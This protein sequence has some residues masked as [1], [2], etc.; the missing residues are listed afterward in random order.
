MNI[1]KQRLFII[2]VFIHS[3]SYLV[4]AQCAGSDVTIEVCNKDADVANRDFD[5]FSQL[6]GSPTAGGTWS[7][8]N[9]EN[10]Y[11][12]NQT[13][14]I[15]D[16]WRINNFGTHSFRYFN[17]DCNQTATVTINLGGYP[18]EDNI[19]GSANA[20]GDDTNVNLH[21]F[22][23]SNVDGKVQD[24][25]GLWEEDPSTVT[26]QL[27]DNI[28]DARAA[29]TGIYIFTYTVPTVNGC[30]SRTATVVLEV[31]PPP[32]AGIA[33]SLTFCA[34]DDFSTYTNFDLNE[35]LA[36]EDPN[37]TW[38]EVG[39]NQLSDLNDSFINIQ[40]LY[41]NF[42]YNTYSFTYTVYPTHPVCE[43]TEVTVNIDIL[44][45]LD[46]DIV[47]D[48]ICFG[49]DYIV[50]LTYDDSILHNGSFLIQYTVNGVS[51]VASASLLDG[52]GSFIVDPDL[53]PLN[54]TVT[55]SVIGIDGVTPMRDVCPTV[56]VPPTTFLVASSKAD[57]QDICLQND[58]TVTISEILDASGNLANGPFTTE[59]ILTA[60]DASTTTSDS[61]ELEFTNGN[62]TF[63]IPGSNFA[64]EGEYEVRPTIANTFTTNCP[65]ADS[66]TVTPLP[67][68]IKL[69]L[70]VDNNC[71]ATQID[72]LVDAP[73]LPNGAYTITYDVTELDTNT[74]LTTNTINFTGGTA[75]YQ[76]DVDA[77]PV[78]NYT[79]SVRSSQNDITPCRIDFEF[80]ENEIFSRGGVP[81]APQ[82]STN[83]IFCLSDFPGGPT[84]MDIEVTAA[85][86]ILFYDTLTDTTILPISTALVDGEDYFI[87][88]TDP[89]NNCEGTERIQVTVNFSN[90][91][92][93]TSTNSNPLFC[94]LDN[95][96]LSD[97]IIDVIP[98]S[99]ITWFN[100]GNSELEASTV[101]VDGQS[102]FAATN[103]GGC[104][105]SER[106][107]VIPTVITVTPTSLSVNNL[108][109]CGLDNPT[110]IELRSLEDETENEVFW[111]ST[112]TSGTALTDDVPL[113]IDTVYYAENYNTLTGCSSNT[114]V[115]VTIDFSDCDPE[116]YD[117][118]IPD[119]FSP[120]ADGRNDTFFIPNIETIFPNYTLEILNR[121]GTTLFKGDKTNPA[122][123]GRNGSSTAPNGV[124]FYIIN[125]NKDNSEPIQGRLYL[126]R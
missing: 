86:D 10:F 87:T 110:V 43:E 41:D 52:I 71:D 121:Y 53:V 55:L 32:N 29:G 64:T 114:R 75:A 90:P 96:T 13:T 119:G 118:F 111:Y 91:D 9:P 19:D 69:D 57:V 20:C 101:L 100:T 66:F 74:I 107:E 44:P 49:S 34:N 83:Q 72:V 16:L 48:N 116:N 47:T 42:G 95:A 97:I 108:A 28:F 85:G 11:A 46:G 84:L 51:E 40:E 80:E 8:A 126:N 65:I 102:Y 60:P 56:I 5:L 21:G 54:E 3:F 30:A 45:V 98:S 37:G 99:S 33:T 89:I 12:L 104:N 26:N 23:G 38:S 103:S 39:T 24:F 25:N 15:V 6:G 94:A 62:A 76:I 70:I 61:F 27:Q 58:A 122:W 50:D 88:N 93:P 77:L 14:G 35:Q 109:V 4:N 113:L 125:Y 82:A 1:L 22:L 124:Y 63:S 120:N 7:T 68:A 73:I 17:T 105:S 123:D 112:E 67:D 115:P 59:Y 31:H 81:E 18:G 117:F 106:L 92:A 79:A 2:V 78:G 36:G